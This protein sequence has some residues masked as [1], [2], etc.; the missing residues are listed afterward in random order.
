MSAESPLYLFDVDGTIH[1]WANRARRNA[2]MPG[3]R[4]VFERYS[5]HGEIHVWT[6][7]GEDW[8][9]DFIA[10][11]ALE[12]YVAGYHAK[13][14]YPPTEEA[15]LGLLGR[16]ATLQFDDDPGERIAD[17]PFVLVPPSAAELAL[18]RELGMSLDED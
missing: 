11:H 1:D 8:A 15:A 4:E 7:G 18:R 14:I 9:H 3:T 13:P 2:L 16:K 12:R 10:L 17:W 6:A 5:E